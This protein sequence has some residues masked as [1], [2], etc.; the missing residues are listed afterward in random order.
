MNNSSGDVVTLLIENYV[1]GE[2]VDYLFNVTGMRDKTWVHQVGEDWP[3]LGDMILNGK[4]LV[5]FWDYSMM[6]DGRG[7][8]M[9]GL[10]LG[11]HMERTKKVK[12][13]VQSEEEAAKQKLGI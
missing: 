2:H 5:V 6:R 12:C 8:I 1:P 9:L 3:M 7:Y 4:T 11:Y 10:I 13:H